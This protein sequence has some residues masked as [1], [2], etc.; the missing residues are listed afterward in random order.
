MDQLYIATHDNLTIIRTKVFSLR[1]KL[2]IDFIFQYFLKSMFLLI[3]SWLRVTAV[4]LP[5]DYQDNNNHALQSAKAIYEMDE[6]ESVRGN[7][8]PLR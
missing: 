5:A 4:I 8:Y 2:C 7:I 6:R 1:L 3:K